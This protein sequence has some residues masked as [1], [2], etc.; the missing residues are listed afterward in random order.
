M[1]TCSGYRVARFCST[2]HQKMA[3]KKAAL[4]G[5][6]TRHKDICGVL[7]K[8]REV[9]TE[10]CLSVLS[11]YKVVEK[12]EISSSGVALVVLGYSARCLGPFTYVIKGHM[13]AG[14]Q[15]NRKKKCGDVFLIS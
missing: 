2:D 11:V 1:L 5:N 15:E 4:G 8:W 13:C 3:S 9:G 14:N 12:A 7:S 6:L 10:T